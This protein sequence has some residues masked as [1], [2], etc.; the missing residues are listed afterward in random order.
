MTIEKALE[1]RFGDSQMTKFYRTELKT[2]PQKPDESLQ[3]LAA[4]VKRLISLAYAECPLDIRKS[5][6][7]QFFVDAIRDEETQ[8][9]TCLIVFTD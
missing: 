5:L 8:L 2:R 7:V 9:S 3:V 6:A 4:N 1:Y